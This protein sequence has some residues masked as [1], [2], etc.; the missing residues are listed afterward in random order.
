MVSLAPRMLTRKMLRELWRLKGQLVSIGLVVAAAVMTLVTLRGTYEALFASRRA[1]YE[2]TRLGDVWSSLERAPESLRRDIERIPGVARVATRVTS[3]ATLDLP[4]LDAPGMGLFVS[5]PDDRRAELNDVHVAAGRYLTPDGSNEVLASESF[6]V[7]NDLVL[8]D[9][10]RAVL[11]GRYRPLSIVGVATSPE[12]AYSAPPG[13]IYPD[14]ERYG[15][16]WIS[17]DVLGPVLDADGA[18]N[19]VSV[20]L[21]PRANQGAVIGEL[22]RV[23]DPYGGLGAYGREDQFSYRILNDE[24]NSNRAMGIVI[25]IVFLGVASFLLHLVLGRLITTQR[26]EI[27]V[28]KAVGYSNREIGWHFLSYSLAAVGV[29]TVLGAAGGVWAGSGMLALYGEYFRF[30]ELVYRLSWTL[31]LLGGGV[32]LV[33]AVA[34]GLLAVRKAA[35]LPPA[36]AMR[37]EPPARFEPGLLERIGVGRLLPTEGRLVLRDLERRPLRSFLAALGVGFSVSIL[38][39]GMFMLDGVDLMMRLQFEVAQQEDLAVSFNRPTGRAALAD[40]EALSGVTR[41]EPFHTLPVRLRAGHRERE[42]AITGLAADSRLRRIVS[43]DGAIHPLPMDGLVLSAL[44]AESLGLMPGGT[45]EVETLVGHRRALRVVVAGVVDD[46]MG[47][48]AY[49]NLD[50]L[51]RLTREGPMISGAYLVVDEARRSALNAEL[52]KAPAVASVVSPSTMLASFRTQLDE[53]LLVSV[54]FLLGFA[55]I[56]SLAVIYNGA[57]ISLSERARELASLRVL[58]FTKRE[59][60]R[61]LFGEQGVITVAGIPIGYV[62]GYGLAMLVTTAMASETYRIPM[63]VSTRTY[64]IAALIT[65]ASAIVSGALV[66]RQLNRLDMISALKTRE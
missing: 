39:I 20:A 60:A 62:L 42:L 28:L 32:S 55:G 17:R 33:A 35:S 51:R 34:G 50:G 48:S 29:G 63:V 2:Q 53:S 1:Y 31:V 6:F 49:M 11:N 59:I 22:D 5:L 13:A 18:F 37:P 12:H 26:T 15:V 47:V 7:A 65:V 38:V 46:L 16:F 61:L 57:R 3:Y 58:G 21:L 56:I 43:A 44:V 64:A 19:E 14:D 25:P 36:E 27:G 10:I 40:L 30:P 52:K 66:Q 8:G 23:L 45:V 24:L 54:A 41:V 4:W 9:T